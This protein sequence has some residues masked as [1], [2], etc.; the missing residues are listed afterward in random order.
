MNDLWKC[1]FCG[2]EDNFYHF[3]VKDKEAIAM[4]G[5]V[6]YCQGCNRDL[7][8]DDMEQILQKDGNVKL[9]ERSSLKEGEL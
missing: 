9:E 3:E 4:S 1:K 8:F 6:Y 2:Y 5:F 7:D